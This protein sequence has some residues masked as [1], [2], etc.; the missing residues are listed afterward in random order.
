MFKTIRTNPTNKNRNIYLLGKKDGVYYWLTEPKWMSDNTWNI[1]YMTTNTIDPTNDIH[2]ISIH[3]H[4]HHLIL[5]DSEE[6]YDF[7]DTTPFSRAEIDKFVELIRSYNVCNMFAKLCTKGYTKSDVNPAK[8]KIINIDL[9]EK[10]QNV[11]IPDI[12]NELRI[13]LNTPS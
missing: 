9:S 2:V 11:T 3:N 1:G 12:F 4:Y 10:I 8:Q 7:F 6:F 5:H 13:L